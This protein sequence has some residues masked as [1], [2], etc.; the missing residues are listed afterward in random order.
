MTQITSRDDFIHIAPQNANFQNSAILY[1]DYKIL[2]NCNENILMNIINYRYIFNDA[3]A[4]NRSQNA[5]VSVLV[6]KN[7][8]NRSE[9]DL[10]VQD[11]FIPKTH[12]V[13]NPEN[14]NKLF[15]IHKNKILKI[16]YY[17][18]HYIATCHHT[19]LEY[20]CVC[21]NLKTAE[22][23][24]KTLIKQ[25]LID[26]Y[27]MKG[28][29][30]IHASAVC[31]N[32][33]NV[34]LFLAGSHSGKTTIFLNLIL[35]GFCPMNDDI[36]MLQHNE[37]RI[38]VHA[39]PILPNI[40]PES[41]AFIPALKDI[42]CEAPQLK[43]YLSDNYIENGN[44]MAVFLPRFGCKRTNIYQVESEEYKAAIIKAFSDH[45]QIQPD[46]QF[47]RMYKQIL[48]KP[49]FVIELSTNMS[50]FADEFKKTIADI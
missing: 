11:G 15:A 24:S 22:Y 14:Q 4:D 17:P 37:N 10:E 7:L 41:L 45:H 2:F 31:D 16:N 27:Y 39:L 47:L 26:L 36:L 28:Y 19:A 21:G 33:K 3:T 30:P 40:R 18:Y 20:E 49:L 25:A 42:Q 44:L 34:C 46:E 32:E 43:T 38:V 12:P 48:A 35:A 29:Y 13:Y 5:L 6:E 8:L 9:Y 1:N 23:V 50:D